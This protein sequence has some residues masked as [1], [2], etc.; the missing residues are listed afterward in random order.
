MKEIIEWIGVLLII[1]LGIALIAFL[2]GGFFGIIG[3]TI[4]YFIDLAWSC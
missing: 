1:I 3:Y 2:V 4:T